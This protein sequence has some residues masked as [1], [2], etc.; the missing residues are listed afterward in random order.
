M[1]HDRK[2]SHLCTVNLTSQSGRCQFGVAMCDHTPLPTMFPRVQRNIERTWL[3]GKF[4]RRHFLA[5]RQ[6]RQ[7][8]WGRRDRSNLTVSQRV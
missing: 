7:V 5:S 3:A 6:K 2:H 1:P 4:A 8:C